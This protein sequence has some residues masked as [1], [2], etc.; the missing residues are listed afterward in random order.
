MIV[1]VTH[2]SV[3]R[4]AII[5]AIE[6]GPRTFWRI[7]VAPLSLTRLSGNKGV[8]TLVSVGTMKMNSWEP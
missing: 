7:D 4:A 3:I 8:W 5:H 6:A 2:A 1:A